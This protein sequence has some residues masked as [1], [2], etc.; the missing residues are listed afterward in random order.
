M[1]E[2]TEGTEGEMERIDAPERA[3]PE[4]KVILPWL[5]VEVALYI[6]IA[7]L[8]AGLR[9]F[10]LD[11]WPL[12]ESEATQALA[13]WRLHTGGEPVSGYSPLLVSGGALTFFLFGASDVTARLI[14]A[15]FGASLAALP[16]LLRKELGRVGALAASVLLTFSPT[17]L[18]FSRYA[19]GGVIVATCALVMLVAALRYM[20]E[21]RPFYLYLGLGAL[22]AGL[23]SDRA[24]YTVLLIFLVALAGKKTEVWRSL[25]RNHLAFFAAFF[26]IACTASLTNLAG[27]QA[28]LDLFSAWLGQFVEGSGV[29]WHRLPLSLL[30]YEPLALAFGLLGLAYALMRREQFGS[31]L[32]FWFGAAL[33]FYILLPGRRMEDLLIVLVPLIL[34]AG[35]FLGRFLEGLARK[36]SWEEEGLLVAVAFPALVY[37]FFQLSAYADRGENTYLVL[38]AVAGLLPIGLMALYWFWFGKRVA[39]YGGGLILLVALGSMTLAWGWRLVRH[40]GGPHELL[41]PA[42][43]SPQV[44]TLVETL[45]GISSRYEGDRHVIALTVEEGT[46]P[47]LAWY[48]RDF[49]EARFFSPIS[50]P[51]TPVVITLA[52]KVEKNEAP[53]KGEYVGQD[54]ALRSWWE[55]ARLTWPEVVQWLLRHESDSTTHDEKVILWVRIK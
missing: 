55:P 12:Q 23:C 24:I 47:V 18:F 54:F 16:Y 6:G 5:T 33:A 52:G 39:F 46:G 7:L 15:L 31:T 11:A 25:R 40:G 38:T 1:S 4:A 27:L 29:A 42:P 3:E 26:F 51:D 34:L 21:R 17:S 2:D 43:T 8:A 48:L 49:R 45:E 53:F 44:R 13:T 20:E 22:A 30:T 28:S 32:G 14:P 41:A 50:E 36:A 19:G 37:L 35:A 9:F 10:N